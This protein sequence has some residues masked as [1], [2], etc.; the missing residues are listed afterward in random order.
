MEDIQYDKPFPFDSDKLH[1]EVGED[2][3]EK[4][5]DAADVYYIVNNELDMEEDLV[6]SLVSMTRTANSSEKA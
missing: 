3:I 6:C 5:V 2:F 1:K 4:S